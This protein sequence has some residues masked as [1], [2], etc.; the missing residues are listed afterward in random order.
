[1]LPT[2]VIEYQDSFLLEISENKIFPI[3]PG[4]VDPMLRTAII[5]RDIR[6]AEL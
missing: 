4:S 2:V 6:K 5:E 3:H 1:L